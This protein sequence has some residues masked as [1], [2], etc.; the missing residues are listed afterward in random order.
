MPEKMNQR[1][2]DRKKEVKLP[3]FPIYTIVYV[4][5]LMESTKNKKD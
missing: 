3:F 2:L 5:H 1:H 4:Q